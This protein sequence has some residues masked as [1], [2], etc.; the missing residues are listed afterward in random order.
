VVDHVADIG[1]MSSTLVDLLNGTAL[2]AL[3]AQ[4]DAV[5]Q[6]ILNVVQRQASI[7]F[8][9][10]KPSTIL[11]RISRRMVITRTVSLVDYRDY[12]MRHPE[13]VAE[14]AK[15]FL[16]KVTEF[17]RDPEAFN[18]L[19]TNVLP[20]IIERERSRSKTL[21]FWSAG[22]ATGEEPYSLA[23]LLADLL[24]NELAEWNIKIFA[25][26][27]DE[28]AINYARRGLYPEN[29]LN[30]LPEDLRV[31]YF[32]RV[33]HG[34]QISKLLRQ[35]VIFGQQDLSRGVPFPRIDIVICRNLLIYFKPEVQQQILEMF[36]FSLHQTQGYLFLGH[37]E[38]IRPSQANYEQVH[39]RLKIYRCLRTRVAAAERQ[40]ELLAEGRNRQADEQLRPVVARP[41]ARPEAH[42]PAIDVLTL[43]RS[44]ELVLGRLPIGVVVVDR[45]YRIISINAAARRLLGVRDL[46]T[47]Q[48][49]LHS[50]RGLPYAQ[51]RA[52]IDEAF[53]N[54][55]T[56]A[57]EELALDPDAGGSGYYVTMTIV[58]VET[59]NGQPDLNIICVQDMT[60][61]VETRRSLESVQAEQ[62][63]LLNE[64]QVT[65][66]RLS[67]MNK[68]LQ[69]ANEEL[70]AANEELMLSQEELQATNEGS[71]LPTRS[72]RPPTR[73]WRP[74]T[75]SCR[76]PTRSLRP[77]TMS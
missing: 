63:E 24:G 20:K 22:C 56:V 4:P 74:T 29:L 59:E 58:P 64:I 15:A 39:K 33:D 12:L 19:K 68:D 16:I 52:A 17:F 9:Q 43:R 71:R 55:S 14:L 6:A 76:L 48:D 61:V 31:Q 37:A 54:R 1:N 47:E 30:N 70:Q 77:Q 50:A 25:T 44:N 49:F 62:K 41:V 40:P 34:F 53:R 28:E 65:N 51:V 27:V 46:G 18:F 45:T 36:T 2:P 3:E 11:R 42:H 21:R 7:D 32:K 26:D 73:S 35:M 66:R 67:D 10:Y 38:T 13:E 23:L 57:M 69:D 72:Y 60:E 75:K 8:S 5:L